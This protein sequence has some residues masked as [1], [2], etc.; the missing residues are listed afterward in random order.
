VVSDGK[1]HGLSRLSVGEVAHVVAVRFTEETEQNMRRASMLMTKAFAALL[2]CGALSD[3]KKEKDSHSG[4]KEAGPATKPAASPTAPG[5]EKL[6]GLDAEAIGAALGAK[7][8][9]TDDGVVRATWPRSDVK[10]SIDGVVFPAPA[11]ITSWAAFTT[12][13]HGAMAMGDTV[14]FEDE[15]NPAIDAAFAHG[16]AITGLHNHFFYDQPKVYFMHIGGHGD[17]LELAAGV[18]ATWDAIKMV[19]QKSPRPAASFGGSA[20]QAGG[21]LDADGLAKIVGEKATVQDGVVKVTLG[22]EATMD[23]AKFAASMGLTTWAAFTGSDELAAIDGDFAMTTAEV[24]PVLHA[25]RKAGIN[26]VA[27]H[28]HMVGEEPGYLFTHFWG[29]GAAPELARGFRAALDAQQA[30]KR[31][32]K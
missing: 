3:C 8:T 12:T 23:G 11:G 20:P 26:I 9:K 13:P 18:K 4:A 15:V 24:Q 22:R 21:K 5:K 6:A 31:G 30:V 14:V 29:K 28:N 27:L 1:Q 32:A 7:T 2:L 25:L 17:P 10:V 16:L 19:R